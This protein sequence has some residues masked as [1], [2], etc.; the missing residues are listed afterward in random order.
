MPID[1]DPAEEKRDGDDDHTA[2]KPLGACEF[3][4]KK[5]ILTT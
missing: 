5:W 1:Y 2:I 3:I 4:T